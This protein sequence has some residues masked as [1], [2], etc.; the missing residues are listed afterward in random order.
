MTKINWIIHVS[1]IIFVISLYYC[2]HPA[3][4]ENVL[5]EK[6]IKN[7]LGNKNKNYLGQKYNYKQEFSPKFRQ[8]F[9]KYLKNKNPNQNC[10][11]KTENVSAINSEDLNHAIEEADKRINNFIENDNK[12][13]ATNPRVLQFSPYLYE[14]GLKAKY[15]EYVTQALVN[16]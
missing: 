8:I 16:R 2:D 5:P 15:Q 14:V 13:K 1:F 10:N 9:I 12:I 11:P 7:D 4:D 3:T 6:Q